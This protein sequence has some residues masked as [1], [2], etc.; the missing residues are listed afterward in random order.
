MKIQFALIDGWH[1]FDQVLPDFFYVD[2]LLEDGGIVAFDDVVMAAINRAV[3]Y[4]LN[5]PNYRIVESVTI[6]SCRKFLQS[7]RYLTSSCDG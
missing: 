2:Q 7:T 3:R 6:L 4:F 5:Y 1:T